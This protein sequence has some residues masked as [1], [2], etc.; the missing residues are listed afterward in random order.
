MVKAVLDDW[1][2]APV[3]PK[4]KATLGF[5]KVLTL[6]PAAVGSDHVAPLRAAGV[7]DAAIEDAVYICAVFNVLDRIADALGFEVPPASY[8]ESRGRA[9]AR[10]VSRELGSHG[11]GRAPTAAGPVD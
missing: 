6:E 11:R 5:L 9:M 3:A 10:Q 1:S 7:S 8:L 2:T 4:L